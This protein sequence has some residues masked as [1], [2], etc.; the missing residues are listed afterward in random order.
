MSDLKDPLSES[1]ANAKQISYWSMKRCFK[2]PTQ[3]IYFA[4]RLDTD[5]LWDRFPVVLWM[6]DNRSHW[7]SLSLVTELQS[8]EY[9]MSTNITK[10][11]NCLHSGDDNLGWNLTVNSTQFQVTYKHMYMEWLR[12]DPINTQPSPNISFFK[13]LGV[14]YHANQ[15]NPTVSANGIYSCMHSMHL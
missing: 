5:C 6:S 3:D 7:M 4:K 14:G 10:S 9:L 13:S 11:C 8:A 2:D 15:H 12:L 1:P